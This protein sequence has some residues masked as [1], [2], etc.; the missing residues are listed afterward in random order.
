MITKEDRR[1]L[2]NAYLRAVVN[3]YTPW[4]T[5]DVISVRERE[6]AARRVKVC[7]AELA[8]PEDTMPIP[9]PALITGCD[10]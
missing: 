7:R 2:D 1:W 4:V 6:F 9:I 10:V 5:N 8:R 3:V